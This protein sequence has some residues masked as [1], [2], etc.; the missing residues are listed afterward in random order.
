[1]PLKGS[2]G[3]WFLPPQVEQALAKF[4]FVQSFATQALERA[5][6]DDKQVNNLLG[7]TLHVNY[8]RI[9]NCWRRDNDDY[10]LINPRFSTK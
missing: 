7:V 3:V 1:M 9:C 2:N 4:M 8:K 10:K 5:N 6:Q